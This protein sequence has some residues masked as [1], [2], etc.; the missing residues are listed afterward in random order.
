MG[1]PSK[2]ERVAVNA[3]PD[4][5]L[6]GIIKRNAVMLDMSA[7]DYMVALAAYALGLPDHAPQPGRSTEALEAL[8]LIG[9]RPML[10][11]VVGP[12][13]AAPRIMTNSEELTDQLAS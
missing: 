12:L 11:S 2:G 10:P 5:V 6:A 7:G 4:T 9:E 1:R 13:S 8:E 3:K